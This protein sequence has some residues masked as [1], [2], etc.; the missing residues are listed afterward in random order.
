[1][2]RRRLSVLGLRVAA[3]DQRSAAPPPKTAD[4]IYA[5]PEWSRLIAAII[6][7]RGRRCEDPLCARAAMGLAPPTR[8]FGDHIIELRDGSAPFDERNIM[9]RCGA[10]HTRKTAAARAERTRRAPEPPLPRTD[11]DAR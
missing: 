4:P 5:S 8:V 10:C 3:F 1:M 2:N 11:P 7:R 6:R 9:L